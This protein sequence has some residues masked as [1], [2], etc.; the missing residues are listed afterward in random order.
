[1]GPGKL[2]RIEEISEDDESEED[3]EVLE[4]LSKLNTE[5]KNGSIR[6]GT[7]VEGVDYNENENEEDAEDFGTVASGQAKQSVGPMS[8]T[9]L[10]AMLIS[11]SKSVKNET[12]HK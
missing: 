12:P 7:E 5:F 11:P 8:S 6:E 3:D 1:M 10:Q 9:R 2:N 4:D